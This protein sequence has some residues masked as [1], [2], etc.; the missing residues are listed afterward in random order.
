MFRNLD[1]NSD[2]V[3]NKESFWCNYMVFSR[4]I[5]VTC[6]IVYVRS[7]GWW[8]PKWELVQF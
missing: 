7:C 4:Q 6:F 1:I 5:K 3:F 8:F 2:L